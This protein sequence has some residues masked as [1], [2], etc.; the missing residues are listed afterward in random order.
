[1]EAHVKLVSTD[2]AGG[3]RYMVV[4][5][6]GKEFNK[7]DLLVRLFN[8][9][10]EEYH[11]NDTVTYVKMYIR[12]QNYLISLSTPGRNHMYCAVVE[13]VV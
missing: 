9:I 11:I 1:M 2:I 10:F 13:E 7:Q 12:N 6:A 5:L 4:E 8:K 3:V